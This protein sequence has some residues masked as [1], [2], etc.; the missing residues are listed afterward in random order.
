MTDRWTQWIYADAP[1]YGIDPAAAN[2]ISLGVEWPGRGGAGDDGT[3]FGPFQ[4]HVGGALPRGRGRKWAESR[5]GVNYALRTMAKSG[6]RGLR[7]QR[8]IEVIARNFEKPADVAGEIGKATLFYHGTEKHRRPNGGVQRLAKSAARQGVQI[9]AS[10]PNTDAAR[11]GLISFLLGNVQSYAQTGHYSPT[12]IAELMLSQQ[13]RQPVAQTLRTPKVQKAAVRGAGK[14]GR[15]ALGTGA[16]RQGV[17][18]KP[19]V[20]QFTRRISGLVGHPLVIGTGT[21]HNQMTVNGN[22]SDHWDGH[23]ADIPASGKS[24]IRLGQAA[25]IAAGMKPSKA[26]KQRGG[27]YNVNGHQIIFNTYE[28]GN[29]TNHLHVSAH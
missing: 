26:R 29:H 22:V 12:G 23:A 13:L 19:S 2:A 20:I 24:L 7:G 16:D 10:T 28:G 6:A 8:A 5:A 3:S 27:L 21:H 1:K 18:T 4:L 14:L 11:S 25:L 15:V 9:A 17:R